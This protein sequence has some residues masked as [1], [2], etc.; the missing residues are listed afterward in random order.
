MIP[1]VVRSSVPPRHDR[2]DMSVPLATFAGDRAPG[3][4]DEEAV[5]SQVTIAL[6]ALGIGVAAGAVLAWARRA[7][8]A[9]A[10]VGVS[11]GRLE[12]RLEVQS[13]ELRRLSDAAN[14]RDGMGEQLR[15]EF[16]GARRA[17]DELATRERER[18]DQETEAWRVIRR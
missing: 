6:L 18:R 1:V 4:P 13:A 3:C 2:A 7:G 16:T 12:A 9:S 15:A 10:G 5:M 8:A 11:D 14:A 17:L